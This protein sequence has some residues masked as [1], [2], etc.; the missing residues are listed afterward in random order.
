MSEAYRKEVATQKGGDLVMTV[1]LGFHT[2]LSSYYACPN[3][4]A[5]WPSVGLAPMLINMILLNAIKLI[6]VCFA[7]DSFHTTM[8]DRDWMIAS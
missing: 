2:L 5:L 4:G 8:S 1:F 7:Q 6:H 3:R